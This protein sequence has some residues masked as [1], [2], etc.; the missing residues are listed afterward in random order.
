MPDALSGRLQGVRFRTKTLADLP[1]GPLHLSHPGSPSTPALVAHTQG[2][3]TLSPEEGELDADFCKFGSP[4][5][6]V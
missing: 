6:W 3:I 4:S 2:S 5:L 1:S